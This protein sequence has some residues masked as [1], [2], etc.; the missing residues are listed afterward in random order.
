VVVGVAVTVTV[1]V[2]M[3]VI[4]GVSVIGGAVMAVMF[5][6]VEKPS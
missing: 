2:R 1:G 5:V 4:V 6:G 3:V